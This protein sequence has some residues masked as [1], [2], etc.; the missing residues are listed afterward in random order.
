M[1]RSDRLMRLMDVLRRLPAPT[2]A[3]RLAAE[4]GVSRRQLYRDIATLR[5]GGALI[6]GEAGVGYHL[7]EDPALPPQSFS[8]PEIEALVLAV[9]ELAQ[10]GDAALEAAGRDA[11]ARIIATLPD[12]Q[13]RQAMHTVLRTFR[14]APAL[15]ALQVD[16][17]MLREACWAESVLTI[18]YRDLRN[19]TTEREIWPLGISYSAGAVKL[20]AWCCLRD[21]WRVFHVAGIE[22]AEAAG[23]SFRPRRVALLHGYA[24]YRDRRMP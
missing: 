18:R 24:G 3:A 12:D 5:A 15:V 21:D 14:P 10:I 8:R 19:R 22:A 4:T 17:A 6:D 20:L 16:L 2:T 9:G 13:T 23:R 7:T 11:L 1:A